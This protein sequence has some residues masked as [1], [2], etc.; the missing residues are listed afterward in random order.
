MKSRPLEPRPEGPLSLQV[1]R[2]WDAKCPGR[3]SEQRAVK[4]EGVRALGRVTK[5]YIWSHAELL[6]NSW[7]HLFTLQVPP[8]DMGMTAVPT[9]LSGLNGINLVSAQHSEPVTLRHQGSASRYSSL[10][11]LSSSLPLKCVRPPCTHQ[12][13][14][15]F[16][17]GMLST[18]NYTA[19]SLPPGLW[20]NVA[21]SAGPPDHPSYNW[22]LLSP[23]PALC[24]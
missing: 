15:F 7:A 22:A 16:L 13:L 21:S 11:T 4:A 3:L 19:P 9:S 6:L 2:T 18:A 12:D 14:L 5:R 17:S 8:H 23:I 1:S 24:L 10:G 20:P